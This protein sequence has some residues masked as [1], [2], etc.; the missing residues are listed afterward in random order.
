M[1]FCNVIL[2]IY[3]SRNRCNRWIA[4]KASSLSF[5]LV[6]DQYALSR[7]LAKTISL[8]FKGVPGVDSC[9]VV[10]VVGVYLFSSW[11][12]RL[13]FE[14]LRSRRDFI[15]FSSPSLSP[16]YVSLLNS[17]WL[18]SLLLRSEYACNFFFPNILDSQSL[19]TTEK[20]LHFPKQR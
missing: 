16:L 11:K 8:W 2:D 19:T 9:H 3:D 7:L 1:L 10:M 6:L 14:Y 20:N 4:G 12:K 13:S 17:L 18:S 5:Y 15:L